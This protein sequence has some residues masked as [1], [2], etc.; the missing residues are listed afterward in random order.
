MVK[1]LP[2]M[3]RQQHEHAPKGYVFATNITQYGDRQLSPFGTMTITDFYIETLKQYRKLYGDVQ[4][5]SPA[6]GMFGEELDSNTAAL[7]VPHPGVRRVWRWLRNHNKL[8]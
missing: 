4:V 6:F 8:K 2:R 5:C 3:N 1:G 7:Y